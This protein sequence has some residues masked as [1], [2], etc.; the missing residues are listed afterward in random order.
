MQN[1]DD[2][3][4]LIRGLTNR[5]QEY[6]AGYSS[7]DWNKPSACTE[8]QVGDVICHLIGGAERQD[9]SMRRGLSGDSGPPPGYVPVDAGN[10]LANNARVH[11]ELRQSLGGQLLPTFAKR[12][13]ALLETLAEVRTNQWENPCWHWRRKNMTASSYLDLRIQELA[14]HDWDIRSTFDAGASLDAQGLGPLMDI[15]S[16][17]LGMTFRPGPKLDKPLVYR[18]NLTGQAGRS[19]S[20][21]VYGD[22]FEVD[23]AESSTADAV[24][25]CDGDSYVLYM[26]GRLTAPSDRL[27]V[28]GEPSLMGRYEGWF[29]GL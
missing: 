19:H 7:E 10:R 5:M 17:W 3:I 27:Q 23:A 21:I 29:K 22:S 8:W 16:R 4:A 24:V 25:T 26:Y 28:E 1:N 15:G 20:I 12:S 11:A 9:D 18:F 14:I 2:R 13:E 6:L